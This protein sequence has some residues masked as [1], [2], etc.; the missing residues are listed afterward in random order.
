M[1]PRNHHELALA[2]WILEEIAS[3]KVQHLA[4][5]IEACFG[6]KDA[7]DEIEE[8]MLSGPFDFLFG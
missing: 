8:G 1:V 4:E 6:A 2:D 3:F 5:L 7:T